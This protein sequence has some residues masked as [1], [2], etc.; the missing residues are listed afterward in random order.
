MEAGQH[1]SKDLN[2]SRIPNVSKGYHNMPHP[3]I[4][5][6]KSGFVTS[7]L[8]NLKGILQ[9]TARI[10]INGT[11]VDLVSEALWTGRTCLKNREGAE[12]GKGFSPMLRGRNSTS[13]S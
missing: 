4:F 8:N 6:H 9:L 2:T 7:N 5:Y 1:S 3:P 11:H 10:K 12:K 13:P